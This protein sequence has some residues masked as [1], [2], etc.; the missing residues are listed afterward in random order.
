MSN[1]DYLS[2][3]I[4]IGDSSVGKSSILV[5]LTD[6]RFLTDPDPT[7]GVEFGSHVVEIPETGERI[8]CQCWDTAGSE[9]FRS[10]TRSYYRGAAGALIVY[11]I[12]HRPSFLHVADWL[13]DVRQH[14]EESC[15]IILVGNMRD[16]CGDEDGGS[17][18]GSS[19]QADTSTSSEGS[20]PAQRTSKKGAQRR[21]EVTTEEARTFAER[22]GIMFVETSAKTGL[23]VTEAFQ[24]A[25]RDIHSKFVAAAAAKG[26]SAHDG[27]AGPHQQGPSRPGAGLV[28][29]TGEDTAK[30]RQCCVVV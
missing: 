11:S 13:R 7:V 19:E 15:S 16:L 20:T 17:S 8:K 6:D 3:F 23:N 1:W 2:K 14:A 29:P 5:R 22:E 25:A 10:I 27:R 24:Q 4:L 9:A 21:R 26:N 30:D 18:E 12:C 28:T